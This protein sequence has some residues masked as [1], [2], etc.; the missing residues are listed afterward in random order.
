MLS[1]H[2]GRRLVAFFGVMYYCGLRPEEAVMLG[3]ADLSL[4]ADDGWGEIHVTT[5]APDAGTRW[6]NSGAERDRRGLKHRGEGEIRTVPIPPPQVRLFRTH[7]DQYVTS[8]AG[9]VF[10]GVKGG[11]LATVT[12]RRAWTG[13]ARPHSTPGST[14]PR[15]R[16]APTT[17]VIR[18]TAGLCALSCRS[19]CWGRGSSCCGPH[20]HVPG[21]SARASR[22]R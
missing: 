4:P 17:C 15:W 20:N 13:P 16:A 10:R 3:A 5:T 7:L 21:V 2:P 1:S 14:C 11:L 9:H 8:P 6:T 12:Y 22:A 18:R 19:R